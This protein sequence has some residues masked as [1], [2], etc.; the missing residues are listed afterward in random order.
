MTA[1]RALLQPALPALP[2]VVSSHRQSFRGVMTQTRMKIDYGSTKS[3][4]VGK[5]ALL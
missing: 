4:K 1:V 3:L 2:T 5:L